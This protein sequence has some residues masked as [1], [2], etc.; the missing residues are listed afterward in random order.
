MARFCPL[1]SG[2]SG[3][4]I[5]IGNNDGGILVDTGM[6]AKKIGEA[7][8]NIGVAPESLIKVY[9]TKGTLSALDDM[10]ILNGK[11]ETEEVSFSGNEAGPLF[12]TPFHTSHDAR[13]SCGYKIDCSDGRKISIA[14]DLGEM[15]EEVFSAVSGSDLVMLESNHDVMMLEN[16]PYPYSLKKRILGKK[17]HLSNDACASTAERLVSGGTTRIYLGHLSRENNMPALAYQTTCSALTMAGAK[18]NSDYILKVAKPV[19]D[20]K[21]MIL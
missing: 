7:L 2:S 1:F 8:F 20:E 3:N 10:G 21:A 18:E 11:F 19:C 9:G 6:S 5:Y 17:G 14:T 13:E 12:V 4:S 15:T 16:G